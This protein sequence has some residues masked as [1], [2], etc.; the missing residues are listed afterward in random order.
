M[1]VARGAVDTTLVIIGACLV[2]LFVLWRSAQKGRPHTSFHKAVL[3]FACVVL[4]TSGVSI[5]WAFRQ[6]L[7]V[8]FAMSRHE[9]EAHHLDAMAVSVQ[10]TATTSWNISAFSALTVLALMLFES[11]TATPKQKSSGPREH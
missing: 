11:L 8:L 2:G 1:V 5:V 7:M 6:L 9:L 10:P 4:T 3:S